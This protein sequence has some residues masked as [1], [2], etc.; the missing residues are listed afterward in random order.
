MRLNRENLVIDEI[1]N[2]ERNTDG[3]SVTVYDFNIQTWFDVDK[4]F[5]TSTR[6][7]DDWINFYTMY[8]PEFDRWEF[9]YYIAGPD[10]EKDFDFTDR[11]SPEDRQLI[12]DMVCEKLWFE[13]EDIPFIEED[14]DMVLDADYWAFWESG[15]SKTKI[16]KWFDRNYSE[17]LSGL[18]NACDRLSVNDGVSK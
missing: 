5:G 10:S 12:I 11:I 15:A 8:V 13:L 6:D 18:I 2:S 9:C 3:K 14:N 17:N 4:Y 1:D 16:W 7:S